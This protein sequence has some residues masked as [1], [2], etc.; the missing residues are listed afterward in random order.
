VAVL[1][2]RADMLRWADA[3][4]VDVVAFDQRGCLSPRVAFVRG[5]AARAAA[6]AA[7]L[8]GRLGEW[9]RRVPRGDLSAAERAEATRWR[10]ALAFAG[11]IWEG[12]HHAVGVAATPVAI[13]PAGRHV[14]VVPVPSREAL[15]RA[16]APLARAVVAVGTDCLSDAP[17]A[18]HA[19][20]SELGRMQRPPLD[21]PVD[22]RGDLSA[23][24]KRASPVP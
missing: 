7:A 5:D 14:L 11:S 16:I 19:R 6:F 17:G 1:S 10:A 21:G 2:D 15:E 24:E 13:P 4:A 20:L 18:P 12:E 22:R 3:L 8:H 23:V 9:S